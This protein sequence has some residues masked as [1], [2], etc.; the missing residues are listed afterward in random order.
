M[1]QLASHRHALRIA[2]HQNQ[3]EVLQT[4]TSR[5]G[6]SDSQRQLAQEQAAKLV[7]AIRQDGSPGLMEQFLAQYGLSS[8]EGVALMCLAE[9]LLRVPDSETIDELIEDKIVPSSWGEH[10]GK[11]SSSLVN[12]AT[13][14]LMLTGKIL[15]EPDQETIG[16]TLKTAVKRLGEPVIRLA[17]KQAM[18]E[19]GQQFVLGET[20]ES[21]IERGQDEVDQGYSYSYDM[22]G[23]AAVTQKDA[24]QYFDAYA[25]AIH[26]IGKTVKSDCTQ[27]NPGISIKLSALHPR[28]EG[29]QKQRVIAELVPRVVTLVGLAKQYSLGLNIDAEEADRLDLSLDVI[30]AV[31]EQADL[32]D[33]QGFGVVVQAYNKSATHLIDFL[34]EL[35]QAHQCQI[36]VRLVKG[37]YWDSEI[38][39]AQL[40]GLENYS[41]FTLKA[42]TDV[43]YLCCASQ[44]FK[45]QD[46][47]YPQFATHNAH[48][49]A[50]IR[51]L[52][53]VDASY[54]FQRLHGM[55]EAAYRILKESEQSLKCR[56]YAPVGRHR[57]L[58]AYL[59]RRLLENGANSSFVNQIVDEDVPIE[60]VVADP[61]A[62]I[63]LFT[64]TQALPLPS[65]LY[66]P[67]RV[68]SSGLDINRPEYREQYRQLRRPYKLSQW[69]AEPIMVS[70]S[71]ASEALSI[72]N[73]ADPAEEVGQVVHARAED[74]KLAAS[75]AKPWS[76]D[77]VERA[78]ILRTAADLY[79]QHS[80]EIFALLSR[81]AGK[82][83][84]DAI[85]ELREAI[86]FLRYYSEQIETNALDQ[87]NSAS[88][89]FV[90]ISPWNFPL[91]IFTGQ[92]SAALA[93]GNAVI[94]KPAESTPLI[95]ALAVRLLHQ[96]GVPV[97]ALQYLPGYGAKVGEALCQLP[98][99]NGV[100]FT[101]S[102]GTAKQIN[103]SMANFVSPG[104]ALIAETGGINAMVVDS[105]AL[106]EQA[107]G[108]I[109]RSAF[110]SAGQR[111]SALRVLYVQEAIA[112][113]F[114]EMLCGAM[115][116]LS[117][118]DPWSLSSDLGPIINAQAK[119]LIEDYIAR[120]DRD[121]Q[122]IKQLSAPAQ[123]HFIAPALI[124]VAGIESVH[125]EVF[126]PVLHLATY[127]ADELDNVIDSINQSGF[128]LTFGLHTRIDDRVEQVVNRLNVG[129]IYV[130]RDQIGAIVGTQPFG[131]EGLSGTG[132]KAGGPSYLSRF[133]SPEIAFT[134]NFEIE[135]PSLDLPEVQRLLD[136][137]S[138]EA[139]LLDEISLPGATG[140]SNR[141]R[142]Y[143]KG[144][145]LCLGPTLAMAEQQ[146]QQ[147]RLRGGHA[148]MICPGTS[149]DNA[150]DGCLDLANLS[151]LDGIDGVCFQ[152]SE[153]RVKQARI[154]LAY[155]DGPI[156]PLFVETD[157][158]ERCVNER[159]LCINTTA[160][161]GNVALLAGE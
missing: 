160:S 52:A 58:L 34:Y 50:A 57:D 114:T 46:R 118:Q 5:F 30:A 123:G 4:L 29:L 15:S 82:T 71:S 142:F 14:G 151:Q 33:W 137:V 83:A 90:C 143:A 91:A 156:V 76:V 125:E 9:A 129:N 124:R 120:A 22:L 31:V 40:Q 75:D 27:E 117:I 131:G 1:T 62:Q 128:G 79:Q 16:A 85:A 150:L 119:K 43:A 81:E 23:E 68:N 161:G 107:I 97:T 17:V 35:A 99:I 100:C 121:G 130:N 41:V 106:P 101:G 74:A 155:R 122:L 141:L 38:K 154:A 26:A 28:Y 45:L 159:H 54:E 98:Q 13:W 20:I 112:E 6:L 77:V 69:Q 145:I 96:A 87:Q 59:V 135:P 63:A 138:V 144:L 65:E 51:E 88:G 158:T 115:H 64:N 132:P 133:Y 55:G 12:A 80:G 53:P 102:T 73:P 7:Q 109:V 66:A 149:G 48:T 32:S 86:D 70:A 84:I 78:S 67:Q 153:T 39:H 113:P 47:I 19:M 25:Q 37:A 140:E 111:C 103:Q 148:V 42:A 61:F 110:Q 146:A 104:A 60:D 89:L 136:S 116:E 18:R 92:L 3:F 44:L 157:F 139:R 93:A 10:L 36:M 94:V 11:S 152:A 21:A 24:R 56:I 126:G 147:V 105:T 134:E 2:S 108:D 49:I 72:F 127:A 8:D 95:A